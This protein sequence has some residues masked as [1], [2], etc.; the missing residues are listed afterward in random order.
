[1]Y[2]A[3]SCQP[4]SADE[5]NAPTTNSLKPNKSSTRPTAI[6]EVDRSP[7]QPHAGNCRLRRSN[8]PIRSRSTS[9]KRTAWQR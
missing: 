8:L 2:S 3:T 9:R 5:A 1:M 4:A 6:A 7:S